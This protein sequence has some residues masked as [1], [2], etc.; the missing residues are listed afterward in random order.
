[1]F[2]PEFN[3]RLYVKNSESDYF[4]FPPPKS[5][6]FFSNIGNPN[7]FLE[8]THNPSPLQVKWSFPKKNIPENKY[9]LLFILFN[10]K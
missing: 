3:I 2:F 9:Q 1:M 8:K 7:I 4:I 10:F 6:F 5:D